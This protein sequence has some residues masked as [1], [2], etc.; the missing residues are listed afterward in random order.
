M[1]TDPLG[2][3]VTFRQSCAFAWAQAHLA[4]YLSQHP[5]AE[6]EDSF[7]VFCKSYEN[8]LYVADHLSDCLKFG[9]PTPGKGRD[10]DI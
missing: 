3:P 4:A 7:P 8:G 9:D 5:G 10:A 1:S 6:Y 2:T